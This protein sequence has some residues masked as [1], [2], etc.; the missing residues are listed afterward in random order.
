M[1]ERTELLS[2]HFSVRSKPGSGT[3]IRAGFTLV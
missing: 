1:R 2:G 3:R